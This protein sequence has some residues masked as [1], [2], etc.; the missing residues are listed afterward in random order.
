MVLLTTS[1]HIHRHKCTQKYTLSLSLPLSPFHGKTHSR[2]A[3]EF[4]VCWLGCV[5]VCAGGR[6]RNRKCEIESA[7]VQSVE[8]TQCSECTECV[9]CPQCLALLYNFIYRER[10]ESILS[11]CSRCSVHDVCNSV[12]H[13]RP[14]SECAFALSRSK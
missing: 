4:R 2:I 1:R 5:C 13:G 8:H 12:R 10:V 14:R 3:T 11:K 9:G 6:K 7:S